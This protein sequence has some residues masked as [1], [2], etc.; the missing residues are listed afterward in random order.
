M[1]HPDDSEFEQLVPS[2]LFLV[3]P[4]LARV[5]VAV[6][7]SLVFC[8]PLLVLPNPADLRL[9]PFLVLAVVGVAAVAGWW[10]T[11]ISGVIVTVLYW[12]YGVPVS[13]S[14]RFLQPRDAIS[15]AAMAAFSAWGSRRWPAGWSGR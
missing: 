1:T 14:F 5:G 2:W 12:W 15:V 9:G 11:A 10:A 8:L 6:A 13:G 4:A 7:V 3:R